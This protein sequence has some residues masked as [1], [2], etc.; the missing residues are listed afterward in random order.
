M[1][2]IQS[3]ATL[4]FVIIGLFI[5][6][7]VTIGMVQG[8]KHRTAQDFF[9]AGRNVPW[10]MVGYSIF[11]SNISA[12]HLV[13]L[14]GAGYM[15]GL[16]QG[17]YEW[18]AFSCLFL[19][20][21][22]FIPYY[23]TTKITTIPEF[24]ERRYSRKCRTFLAWLNVIANTFIRLGVGLYAGSLVIMGF[25]GWDIWTCVIFLSIIAASY[26]IVGG[27]AAVVVTE[28][29]SA[30][31]M[32]MGSIV[33]AIIGL[34]EV[35]GVGKLVS[36]TPP[37]YWS[38]LRP[39]NDPV[40]PWYAIVFGYPVLGIWYWCTDQLIV[41][42]TLCARSIKHGQAGIVFASFLKIMPVFIFVIPGIMGLIEFPGLEK[43]DMVYPTILSH[44]LPVGLRGVM[45]AVLLAA[46]LST[47][48]AGLNSIS[49][50]FTL[51]IA[52]RWMP[53]AT[54]KKRVLV[55]RIATG[56]AM[57]IAMVWA[58]WIGRFPDNL[59]LVL[60]QLLAAISPP[61]VALFLLGVLW[62]KATPKAAELAMFVGEPVCLV[63]VLTNSLHWPKGFW[64]GWL[65][66]MFLSFL[67]FVVMVIFMVIVSYN[68]KPTPSEKMLPSLKEINKANVTPLIKVATVI[69]VMIMIGLYIVF[70]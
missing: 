23:M 56:V 33:L 62:K 11:A 21:F 68:S 6:S 4:D 42:R 53:N 24:L 15:S 49:T 13:G 19:L 69:L 70:H 18:M 46:I 59:F 65:N 57:L 26:T 22:I 9:L 35:G 40:M 12:E 60:N 66:F 5:I 1:D 50:I 7:L 54:E 58:P 48:D 43:A 28:S 31:I 36:D 52:A 64:P 8:R 14:A 30:N 2:S 29:F 20:A 51:D 47:M 44:W 10:W 27:L 61:L 45:V 38:M 37:E 3:L 34:S 41:Q 32:I 67:L 17:N 16:L 55:A 39:A 25:F 63:L